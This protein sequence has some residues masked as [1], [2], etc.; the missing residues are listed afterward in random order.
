M[1]FYCIKDFKIFKG[2]NKK[3]RTQRKKVFYMAVM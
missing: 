2:V 3:V 1:T